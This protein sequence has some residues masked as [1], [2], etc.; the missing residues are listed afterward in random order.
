MKLMYKGKMIKEGI[1]WTSLK[2]FGTGSQ[3]VLIG[4]EENKQLKAATA[5]TFFE[6]M[7]KEQK[8]KILKDA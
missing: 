6:D 4:T 5:I 3:L 1:D 8:A 2:D 7:T